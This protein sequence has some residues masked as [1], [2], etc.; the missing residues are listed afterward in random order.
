MT[1]S[2]IERHTL[3][4][5]ALVEALITIQ[6]RLVERL[7]GL[8]S[9]LGDGDLASVA[10]DIRHVHTLCTDAAGIQARLDAQVAALDDVARAVLTPRLRDLERGARRVALLRRQVGDL[11]DALAGVTHE[12]IIANDELARRLTGYRPGAQV[13]GRPH[14]LDQTA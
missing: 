5:Q 12:T 8:R 13:H 11:I 1:R 9:A 4:A 3:E 6:Q 14:L 7:D 2:E 10:D